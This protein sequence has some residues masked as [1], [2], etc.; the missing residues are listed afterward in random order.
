MVLFP[1]QKKSDQ[2]NLKQK[3]NQPRFTKFKE[4]TQLTVSKYK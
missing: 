2:E 4:L 3:C 1:D